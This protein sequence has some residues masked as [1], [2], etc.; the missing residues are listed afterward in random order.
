MYLTTGSQ[1]FARFGDSGSQCVKPDRMH[2]RWRNDEVAHAENCLE[3]ASM[4]SNISCRKID[5]VFL[6]SEYSFD[7]LFTRSWGQMPHFDKPAADNESL[8]GLIPAELGDPAPQMRF[9][10]AAGKEILAIIRWEPIASSSA[11]VAH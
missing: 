8:P 5:T 11:C 6:M 7:I 9:V 1:Y 10:A 2:R 4:Q 3:P